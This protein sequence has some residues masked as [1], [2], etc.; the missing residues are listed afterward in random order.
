[1]QHLYSASV[2]RSSGFQGSVMNISHAFEIV[3]RH[4]P[5]GR[6]PF[7]LVCCLSITFGSK[8]FPLYFPS[9]GKLTPVIALLN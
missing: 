6:R 7:L 2:H 5:L 3:V 8:I 1:M 4:F 9:F